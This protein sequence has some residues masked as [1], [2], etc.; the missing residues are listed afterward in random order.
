MSRAIKV[1]DKVY[2]E[3]FQIRRREQTFSQVIE[4]LLNA[5]I[6]I[7][8]LITVLEGQLDYREWQRRQLELLNM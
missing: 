3:L 8:E 7:F 1:E 6:K 5:R 2:Q 4:D